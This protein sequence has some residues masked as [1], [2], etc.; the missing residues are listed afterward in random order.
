MLSF[1]FKDFNYQE[2]GSSDLPGYLLLHRVNSGGAVSSLFGILSVLTDELPNDIER[3][4]ESSV[5]NES[6]V[7]KESDTTDIYSQSIGINEIPDLTQAQAGTFKKTKI[8]N[9]HPNIIARTSGKV[10]L[11]T[12]PAEAF[13]ALS[14]KHP[15]TAAHFAQVILTRFQRVTF[16]TLYR[17][18][19]LP[20]ELLTI[21]EKM[22]EI[23]GNCIQFHDK[24]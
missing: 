3:D 14:K 10:T 18:L 24:N 12:I 6:K 1:N 13:H 4:I 2:D 23:S 15:I 19:G 5:L 21:E 11:A 7:T 8:L 22:N 16:S 20:R 17:Y 9:I